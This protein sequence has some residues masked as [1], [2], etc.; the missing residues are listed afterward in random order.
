MSKLFKANYS[1]HDSEYMMLRQEILQHIDGYQKLRNMMYT[2]TISLLMLNT[3]LE[4]KYYLYLLPLIVII[5]SYIQSYVYRDYV[6]KDAAYLRVFHESA[7]NS[8]YKWE[9]RL[10]SYRKSDDRKWSSIEK[11]KIWICE[12]ADNFSYLFTAAVCLIL[13][14]VRAISYW[15][16]NQ[17]EHPLLRS[18]IDSLILILCVVICVVV[19]LIFWYDDRDIIYSIWDKL[20]SEEIY[21]NESPLELL[22][23]KHHKED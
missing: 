12:S 9:T 11:I 10:S 2:V 1:Q 7:G 4:G 6:A 13:Y 17:L 16:S 21:S 22:K 14:Y 19:F 8:K 5:P 3:Y 18:S 15:I 23:D 20:K